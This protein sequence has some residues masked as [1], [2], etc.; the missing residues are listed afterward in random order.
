M[1]CGS[2]SDCEITN[3]IGSFYAQLIFM[4]CLQYKCITY[5]H[6]VDNSS[7]L[8]FPIFKIN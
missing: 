7:I 5:K 6:I 3:Q 8:F 4:C 1:S 2:V